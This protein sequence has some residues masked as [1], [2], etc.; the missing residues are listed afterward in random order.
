MVYDTFLNKVKSG[1]EQALGQ[2]Y[3]LTLRK[4][5]KNNGLI[6]DGLCISKGRDSVA[7]TIYLN[8]CYR[9]YLEGTSLTEITSHLLEL[10]RSN[11]IPPLIHPNVLSD[12]K[13]ME[14]RI[15]CRLVN[16]ASNEAMLR[17]MPHIPWLDL[18][19]VF[20]LF[21]Q[22]D[23]TGVMTA[24]I[25]HSH[26]KTW[27][28]RPEELFHTA[29]NNVS[30]LFPPSITDMARILEDAAGN[31]AA[32]DPSFTAPFYVLTNTSGVNGAVCMLYPN[33]L[34]HFSEGIEQDVVILPSSIHEVLLLADEE[35]I[36]YD[37]LSQMVAQINTS[38]VLPQDRLSNQVYRYSR[39]SDSIEVVS[40]TLLPLN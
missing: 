24:A 21:L 14:S 10:Y 12:Y 8:G 39:K 9:Q 19:I 13:A 33:V 23:D 31:F 5:P 6:L 2:E 1:M 38:E 34:K 29:L 17:E 7:P 3:E 32:S 35:G 40:S 22:E 27:G 37:E 11:E 15:A 16:T 28:I 36:S 25:H 4:I 30:R 18:S 26:L 20:Y